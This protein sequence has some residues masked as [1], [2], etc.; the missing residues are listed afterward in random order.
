MVVERQQLAH[1]IETCIKGEEGLVPSMSPF[2]CLGAN[3]HRGI[4]QAHTHARAFHG[5]T[6]TRDPGY[7]LLLRDMSMCIWPHSMG[8]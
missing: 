6:A 5:W 7:V 2:F 1:P 4:F 8:I 3:R